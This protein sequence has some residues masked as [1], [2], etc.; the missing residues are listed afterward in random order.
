M[1]VTLFLITVQLSGVAAHP[2]TSPPPSETY[3][4]IVDSADTALRDDLV[5]RG[6]TLLADYGAFSLWNVPKNATPSLAT[7]QRLIT[8]PSFDTILFRGEPI[9][10]VTT[11][12]TVA[13]TLQQQRTD[14]PQFWLVQFVGP[15]KDSWL[16]M[17]QETGVALVS[18]IP[19]HA[20][21]VWGD[22][23]S[24]T[25]LDR[26]V[27]E[28][29][30]V[31]WAGAYHPSYRLAPSLREMATAQ[32]AHNTADTVDV[33]VQL[34][35]TG[36]LKPLLD[37]LHSLAPTI[38]QPPSKINHFVMISLQLPKTAIA[39]IAT[40]SPVYNIEP[41]AERELFDEVQGQ[42]IAGNVTT[43]ERG[44]VVPEAPG[45]LEW[46]Q[47]KGFPTDPA[48]YPIVDVVDDG[49]DIG[50][51][52]NVLHPDFYEFGDPNNPD[53]IAY[54]GNC[55]I[56]EVGN[57]VG[58]HGNLNV[59]IVGSYNQRTGHPHQDSL[60]YRIGL[61]ISPYGRL[62]ATKV[63]ENSG[64]YDSSEC[65]YSDSGVVES[66][67]LNGGMISSNSW[68]SQADGDYDISSYVYDLLTRDASESTSG[69]QEMLHVFS[70]GNSGNY[71][72]TIGSPATAK[73]VLSVG[74]TENVR[75]EGVLDG[76]YVDYADNA[77]DVAPFSSRGPTNDN[78]VKP[79]IIAP[80][81]HVQG[82]A[83]QDPGFDGTGVCGAMD[84]KYYPE[85]QTLY[86]W[87]SGT[88]HSAPAVAG[89]ASLAYEYYG[90]M[91]S[92]GKEPSPAMLKAL[93]LNST[94]Y[95]DGVDSGDTLPS[96]AQGWGDVNLGRLFDG[97]PRYVVDQSE[98]FHESGEVYEYTG[99]VFDT[100]EPLRITL[101]WTD[102]PGAIVG[103]SETNN[104]DLEVTIGGEIYRGNVFDKQYSLPDGAFDTQNNVESVFLPPGTMG[105]F[106]VRVIARN[107][108]GNGIPGDEDMT[109]QD[110]ALVSYNDTAGMR[111][112]GILAGRV[113]DADT[114]E[115]VEDALVS[116][117]IDTGQ[118]ISAQ[119]EGQGDYIL[120]LPAGTFSAEVSAYGYQTHLQEDVAITEEATTTLDVALSSIARTTVRGTVTDEAGI[121]LYAQIVVSVDQF[122]QT[123]F[124]DPAT[125]AYT[126]D[127]VPDVAHTM[128]T[129]AV[130]DGQL[131]QA[132]GEHIATI[133]PPTGGMKY[134]VVLHA[135]HAQCSAPTF[136]LPYLTLETFETDDGGYT[137]SWSSPWEWGKPTKNPDTAFSGEH[138]WSTDLSGSSSAIREGTLTSP[139]FDVREG[140]GKTLALS[141]EQWAILSGAEMSIQI[142]TDGGESWN[143]I[144]TEDQSTAGRWEHRLVIIEEESNLDELAIQFVLEPRSDYPSG[145][146]AIDNVGI[147]AFTP[148]AHTPYQEDFEQDNGGYTIGGETT[149]WEWGM[150]ESGPDNAHSGSKLWATNLTG[151]Y[152]SNEESTLASPPIDLSSY[153]GQKITLSWWQWVELED[154]YDHIFAEVSTDNG[155]TW[156]NIHSSPISHRQ[157]EEQRL[158]LEE[159]IISSLLLRFGLTTDYDYEM[160]GFYLD[161]ISITTEDYPCAPRE[162]GVLFGRVYDA[163]TN[164]P[165][166]DALIYSSEYGDTTTSRPTEDDSALPDGWYWIFLPPGQ[167]K[168]M[169]GKEGVYD[170]APHTVEVANGEATRFDIAL[171]EGMFT[172]DSPPIEATLSISGSATF[173]LTITN[174]GSAQGA[175]SFLTQDTGFKPGEVVPSKIL[176][177]YRLATDGVCPDG[178]E[179]CLATAAAGEKRFAPD[180]RTSQEARE[181][182][183]SPHAFLNSTPFEVA[184]V[185]TAE[186]SH[187]ST[188]LESYSDISKVAI[189]EANETTP[190]TAE[191][192]QYDVVLLA[193]DQPY[194]DP[195]ALGDHLADYVDR[196]GRVVQTVPTFSRGEKWA[197]Q[198][199]FLTDGYAPLIGKGE[200]THMATLGDYQASHPIMQGVSQVS[201]QLRQITLLQEGAEVV[202]SWNDGYPMV[203]VKGSVVTINSF[204]VDGYMWTGDMDI[205]V[206][207]SLSWLQSF[208]FLPW[209]I[210]NPTNATLPISATEHVSIT[211]D[212][213]GL[214]NPLPGTYHALLMLN[215]DNPYEQPSVPVTMTVV[216]PTGWNKIRGTISTKGY[217]DEHPTALEGA[218]VEL[219]GV[220]G[221]ESGVE[222]S[223][224]I[225]T[226]EQGYYELW[227]TREDFPFTIQASAKGYINAKK[228]ITASELPT[229]TMLLTRNLT[230]P[231][232]QPCIRADRLSVDETVDFGTSKTTRLSVRNDGRTIATL[233]LS[234]RET[235]Y[236]A[237]KKRLMRRLAA[238]TE[239]PYPPKSA[240]SDS[241]FEHPLVEV[242]AGVQPLTRMNETGGNPTHGLSEAAEWIMHAPIPA[243]Y[244]RMA[245]TT[246]DGET[247]YLFGGWKS[248][249]WGSEE[250]DDAWSYHI[251]S[252]TWTPLAPLPKPIAN[253]QAVCID[254]LI[255]I[256]GG[257]EYYDHHNYFFIYDPQED[258]W[259][260]STWPE[261]R[262]P[263]LAA[264]DGKIYAVGNSNDQPETT[265]DTWVYDPETDS[266]DNARAPLP[267]EAV[268]GELLSYGP[269]L[270]Q[271][272]GVNLNGL[273]NTVYRY[274]P[275]LNEWMEG[276]SLQE[277]RM[278]PLATS[279]GDSIVVMGGVTGFGDGWEHTDTIETYTPVEDGS[280]EWSYDE[281]RLPD[282][283]GSMAGG[284]G[285][286][287]LWSIGG[288]MDSDISDQTYSYNGGK[289]CNNAQDAAWLS[290]TPAELTLDP[291]QETTVALT[292]NA[293]VEEV[294][295]PGDYYAFLTLVSNDP[296]TPVL[297]IPVT[298]TV[299]PT[300]MGKITGEV[301][302]LGYCNENPVPIAGAEVVVQSE[303]TGMTFTLKTDETGHYGQWIEERHSP[304][305]L[306][307]ELPTDLRQDHFM[308]QTLTQQGL[309]VRKKETTTQDIHLRWNPHPCLVATP[310][311][312]DAVISETITQTGSFTIT[313]RGE[314]SA[315]IVVREAGEDAVLTLP[316]QPPEPA[317]GYK[318]D[319][320]GYILLDS[321]QPQG[322][323]YQWVE[324]SPKEGGSG[325][326]I[327]PLLGPPLPPPDTYTGKYAWPI[328]PPFAFPFYGK[329]YPQFAI[330]ERGGIYFEDKALS[331]TNQLI[332][333]EGGDE[334]IS[335]LIAP[336]WD[337]IDI[338][339]GTSALYYDEIDSG[340]I[341][342]FEDMDMYDDDGEDYGTWQ[343]ILFDNGNILFQY[344][345]VAPDDE[346][347]SKAYGGDATVGIQ[348]ESGKGLLYSYNQQALA[349]GLA[350]CFQHPDATATPPCQLNTIPWIEV[351]TP[352][353][354]LAVGETTVVS[355]MFDNSGLLD[356]EY[357][358]KLV[359]QDQYDFT[360]PLQIPL[361]MKSEGAKTLYLPIIAN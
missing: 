97:L 283:I 43:D 284:C 224:I 246:C 314:G 344:K 177:P 215:T 272:G 235:G 64:Y 71:Q 260:E 168:V 92:F 62:A 37:Q 286:G 308:T 259:E 27:A 299:K 222:R 109:D 258:T 305:S 304:L 9:T 191:L 81:T 207:N 310:G 268:Y 358:A 44:N 330:S 151:V 320:F 252:D 278:S 296:I 45:Y 354:S 205:I 114:G 285:D 139:V 7:Q 122:R 208:T 46:L 249:G 172:I 323:I 210:E 67:Y 317:S 169:V 178:G 31:Q 336:F 68:G 93:L 129:Q 60:G 298:M 141:W 38:H 353:R 19:N 12:P 80:G 242:E 302:D 59:G 262:T 190:H 148:T 218:V 209:I 104:L 238:Q 277:G 185:T 111:D 123:V 170:L 107:I 23:E 137:T 167:Q 264:F 256:V 70:A 339:E 75:D 294:D 100:S 5:Q 196:G 69:N 125:G 42:I 325:S 1:V 39:D 153:Q 25:A 128:S 21:I 115:G 88:S 347:S 14:D 197:V 11:A 231:W 193:T 293:G 236:Q 58:G 341:I 110:F 103:D 66:V 82:P 106:T 154:Y 117:T 96:N 311:E 33:T 36:N 355:I 51:A 119:T 126:I 281:F 57:G 79:D 180:I 147:V 349:N 174:T 13:S 248:G 98:V 329:Q 332:P 312:T 26:L 15:V 163:N 257:Y 217:C 232:E 331:Y 4:A 200:L 76:C 234:D 206:H 280:G 274:D 142:S 214:S 233:S 267:A 85:G 221:S 287:R 322:P 333:F 340:I 124:T 8:P 338:E 91:L 29:S 184:I 47:Q 244:Y 165:I 72:G 6:A 282:K 345:G 108:A 63:F 138:V 292:F 183:P 219:K 145:T 211:L 24:L 356:G 134:D 360:P 319:G 55:T 326:P 112:M 40:W 32:D 179:P 306:S 227:F 269:Y 132:Y 136:H 228:T 49:L 56:D 160:D 161:D 143:T 290:E 158:A 245:H 261:P 175:F 149:S 216:A 327:T 204:M 359:V 10:P 121:P 212:A 135:N 351:G 266:W 239:L 270:Y 189:I 99:H 116:A 87:S 186:V 156:K 83:S 198:G 181:Y 253:A 316:E 192:L 229:G 237:A 90:R 307:V 226:D 94:R 243:G 162:G 41:W 157:W 343:G 2:P 130:V 22:G 255:Y 295:Q 199:R 279:Y 127:L 361:R 240:P 275:Q 348:G 289:Q 273:Q 144:E 250:T 203:A 89:A 182:T 18:Y 53:R 247:F 74:A 188:M 176:P 65:G 102:A 84:G 223:Q 263:M 61:G 105:E 297:S 303:T 16:A 48:A 195:V 86:T 171:K 276:P 101:A 265:N 34:Y 3:K 254:D 54:V 300:T 350:I 230:L 78:R 202:A 73:N 166:N 146:V 342:T 140:K 201:D 315:N 335:L 20:Y 150:P 352:Q 131:S 225:A 17:V 118:R 194:A 357:R 334:D 301:L 324:I 213:G 337:T 187:L 291:G 30:E 52:D 241:P 159:T 313:N 133:T 318:I 120:P 113:T 77:D 50:L 309:V 35:D 173:P 346:E 251:P 220:G 288:S 164:E 271:I 152:T 95:L 28:R 328:E 155:R 321:R